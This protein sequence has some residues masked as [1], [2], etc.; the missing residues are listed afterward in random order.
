MEYKSQC[1]N[2]SPLLQGV[3]MKKVILEQPKNTVSSEYVSTNKIY[4]FSDEGGVYKL[5]KLGNGN[6]WSW[7]E[8]KGTYKSEIEEHESFQNAVESKLYA[9]VIEFD[10]FDEFINHYRKKDGE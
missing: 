7:C 3:I 1:P 9:G 4:A 8:I 6:S 10:S 5:C 2:Y